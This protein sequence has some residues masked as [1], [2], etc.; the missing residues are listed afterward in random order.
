MPRMR[1]D[2]VLMI[3]A[4]HGCDPGYPGTDHTREAI[5]LLMYGRNVKPRS[6]GTHAGFDGISRIVKNYLM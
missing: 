6:L 1:D 2:D 3:T 4:D 5:P